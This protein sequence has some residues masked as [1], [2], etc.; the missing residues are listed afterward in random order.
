MGDLGA[1]I[2]DLARFLVGDISSVCALTKTFIEKRPISQD[3]SR[4]ES[5]NVDDAFIAITKFKNGAIGS[6]EASRFCSGRKNFQR[7]EIHGTEGSISFNLERLNE[8][9]VYCR[10]EKE[11]RM[12][13]KNIIVTETVHPYMENWWPHGHIIGWEHTF[14]HEVHHLIDC[15][16][17]DR[18]ISPL[19]ASFYDGLKCQEILDAV[20]ASSDK[21]RWIDIQS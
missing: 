8:L 2:V 17:N 7:I 19:G 3:S 13:F 9:D 15:I 10:N 12:G 21:N 11:D 18:E 1:H 4:K 14:V 16:V 6:I 5:V 20:L